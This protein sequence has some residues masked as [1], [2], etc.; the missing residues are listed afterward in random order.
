MAVEYDW[1]C[2]AWS[3]RSCPTDRP[4]EVYDSVDEPVDCLEGYNCPTSWDIITERSE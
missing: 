1:K 2:I 4:C 3:S